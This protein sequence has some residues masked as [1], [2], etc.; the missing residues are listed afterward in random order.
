[1]FSSISETGIRIIIVIC[2]VLLVLYILLVIFSIISLY[3][4]RCRIKNSYKSFIVLFYEKVKIIRFC[5]DL[6]DK[7]GILN[8]EYNFNIIQAL[9]NMSYQDCFEKLCEIYNNY[10]KIVN[11]N[12][13][14]LNEN[15]IEKIKL[16]NKENE[17][18]Y[19]RLLESFNNDT[20]GYNYWV[21]NK[22]TW[23]FTRLFG[24]RKIIKKGGE[25]NE[26]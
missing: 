12:S 4:F 25:K 14:T 10:F 16:F 11:E 22:S 21:K 13:T 2:V 1:M 3:N 19:F 15:D 18:Q 7:Q 17:I 20:N 23:I 6:L 9:D 8:P 24:F 5:K 26:F